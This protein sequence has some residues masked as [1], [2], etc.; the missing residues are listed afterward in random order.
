MPSRGGVDNLVQ[1][2]GIWYARIQVRGRDV[3]RSLRTSS[4]TEAK[5]RLTEVLAQAEHFRFYGEGRHTWKEAVVEWAASGP[6]LSPGTLKRYLV[7]LGQLRGVLDELYV[8]EITP[9]TIAQ[10]GRRAGVSNATRRRDITAVSVVLRWCAS[11]NWREDNPAATWDRSVIK[12]RRDPI[13][14]PEPYD[15]NCVAGTAP[16]NFANLIRF[17]QYTGMRE[18][19][20]ASL[21]RTQ[22]DLRRAAIT[23]TKTKTNRPR[24]VPLDERALGTLTGTPLR[25]GCPFVFWHP[26]GDRYLNVA[27]RFAAIVRRGQARAKAEKRPI[28]RAFRFHDLRHWF[29]VDYLRRGGSIYTLQQIL[30]HSSIKTTEIYLAYLTPVE[31]EQAKSGTAQNPAQ[32]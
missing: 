23:L 19:E 26:P 2:N 10:I 15:I 25:L 9:R 5:K 24:S 22:I 17:A 12:E 28:P 14:L 7:S 21:E 32:Q 20:C 11:Q 3:R 13:V 6:E 16:G 29:A 1:R 18:E 30:G 27:S 8:D 31:Q 4:R